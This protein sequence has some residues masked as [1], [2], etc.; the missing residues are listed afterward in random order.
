LENDKQSR[1]TALYR[2]EGNWTHAYSLTALT[3]ADVLY[4]IKNNLH[5]EDSS[6]LGYFAGTLGE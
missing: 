2:L 6:L 4:G 1:T 3:G 5:S